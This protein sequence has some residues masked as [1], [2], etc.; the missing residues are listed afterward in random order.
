MTPNEEKAAK[1]LGISEGVLLFLAREINLEGH[2]CVA[3]LAKC[4]SWMCTVSPKPQQR[5][6]EVHNIMDE[7]EEKYNIM[8]VDDLFRDSEGAGPLDSP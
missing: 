4:L 6:A 7:Y 5:F 3:V 2:E 8:G 1:I